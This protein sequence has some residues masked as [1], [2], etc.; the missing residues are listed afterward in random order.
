M[1]SRCK[2]RFVIVLILLASLAVPAGAK[3]P[4]FTDQATDAIIFGGA[5]LLGLWLAKLMRRWVS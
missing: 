4:L 3:P 1:S 5:G 2:L